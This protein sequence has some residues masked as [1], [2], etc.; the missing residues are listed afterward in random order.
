MTYPVTTHKLSPW[1]LYTLTDW[2]GWDICGKIQ[3][4]FLRRG[5]YFSYDASTADYSSVFLFL[6]KRMIPAA[7]MRITTNMIA[8]AGDP[9]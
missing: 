9:V 6:V 2:R 4:P 8:I 3:A 1:Y 5:Q 7:I